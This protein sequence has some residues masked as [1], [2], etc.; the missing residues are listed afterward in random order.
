MSVIISLLNLQANESENPTLRRSFDDARN[1]IYAMAL[2]HE[3]L[4]DSS[5][6]S[7]IKLGEYI[8]DLANELVPSYS[9]GSVISLSLELEDPMVT[10]DSAIPC[11]LIFN[12]LISNSIK[13]A[14]PGGRQG[15]IS[16]SVKMH[17]DKTI[18]LRVAD[19]GVG[20]PPGFEFR[21]DGRMG[22][23]TIIALA[24]GQLKGRLS[25]NS[26]KGLTC[27]VSFVQKVDSSTEK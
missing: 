23:E 18:E 8:R 3:K 21:H 25:F 7:R 15:S 24:E 10:I 20:F 26:G 2:V 12:E 22:L 27:S 13:Y 1:R 17:E 19:D 5:D 11:G 16:A 14:F 9:L 6:L 4:Y